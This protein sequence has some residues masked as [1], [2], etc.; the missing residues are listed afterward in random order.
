MMSLEVGWLWRGLAGSP[1]RTGARGVL[2]A[3]SLAACVRSG[4]QPEVVA[5]PPNLVSPP[6]APV[7]EPDRAALPPGGLSIQIALGPDGLKIEE[8]IAGGPGERAGLRDNDLVLKVDGVSVEGLSLNDALRLIRG[9]VGSHVT[10]T[11]QREGA[12]RDFGVVR[13]VVDPYRVPTAQERHEAFLRANTEFS[14]GDG[15]SPATAII[16]KPDDPSMGVHL[17]YVYI[18]R[19]YPDHVMDMQALTEVDG[20]KYDAIHLHS[21]VDGTDLALYFDISDFFGK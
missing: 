14:G 21:S 9:P 1:E 15:S 2:L 18:R 3:L 17:E 13:D 4:G 19:V 20:K 5:V 16:L 10:L 11:V 8:A 7:S 6:A 12:L